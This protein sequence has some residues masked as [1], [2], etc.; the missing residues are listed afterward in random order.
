MSSNS[1]GPPVVFLMGPT[2]S[3]KTAAACRLVDRF[4]C[5]IVSVD[6]ALVYRGLDIGTAKPTPALLQRYPHHLLDL[7]DPRESYSAAQFRDDAHALIASIRSRGRIP[8]LVGGTGLYFRVLEHGIA[9][10]P[11]GDPDVRR[12]L[13]E[14]L[15]ST[16]LAAM[17]GRLTAIDPSSARRI[18]PNDQQRTLRALEIFAITGQ[19]MSDLLR[20]K[21]LPQAQFPI[22]KM[23]LAPQ[24][25]G[26][27][28]ARIAARF[29]GMLA[30][31]FINEVGAL[32]DRG[33]LSLD[34]PALRAVGYR[35]IW[36]YLA[37]HYRFDEM[38]E[39]GII[40][41]RQLAKRQLTWFRAI[42]DAS[43]FDSD[44]PGLERQLGV[45]LKRHIEVKWP[46]P[47]MGHRHA[48]VA[49]DPMQ[50]RPPKNNNKQQ[51]EVP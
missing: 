45:A 42:S 43:W 39:R 31:G 21:A 6:S 30:A 5:E 9:A 10:V 36:R 8:L 35:V 47:T 2:A 48:T 41:T 11:A 38:V 23:I 40:A 37:G 18:H 16:G 1:D 28:H 14:E 15:A 7:C 17:H 24:D 46:G 4:D 25:R 34:R 19:P 12:G 51:G 27:L 13:E 29:R 26:V 20:Q 44:D 50:A 32:R 3:G 33:D 49:N 22:I